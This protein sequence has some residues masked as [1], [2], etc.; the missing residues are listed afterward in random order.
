MSM[1]SFL[2][3]QA[4]QKENIRLH[5]SEQGDFR[6]VVDLRDVLFAVWFCSITQF[7]TDAQREDITNR[8]G[9]QVGSFPR[10]P[11]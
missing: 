1:G 7:E 9:P 10:N 8:T 11:P 4:K 2:K 3:K 5:R 6:G